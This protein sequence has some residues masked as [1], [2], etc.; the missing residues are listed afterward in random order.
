MRWVDGWGR[1]GRLGA[2]T[3]AGGP[4]GALL[5]TRSGERRRWEGRAWRWRVQDGRVEESHGERMPVGMMER[6]RAWGGRRKEA[7]GRRMQEPEGCKPRRR[8]RGERG[9]DEGRDRELGGKVRKRGRTGRVRRGILGR[10]AGR[11]GGG[12]WED[13]AG[14]SPACQRP[15]RR[16]THPRSGSRCSP[17]LRASRPGPH[18][19]GAGA[20]EHRAAPPPQP[21]CSAAAVSA[22]LR[23][24][25]LSIPPRGSLRRRRRR[26]RRLA[27]RPGLRPR[28]GGEG[29][30]R[31]WLRRCL[32]ALP[33]TPPLHS[34]PRSRGALAA[35]SSLALLQPRAGGLLRPVPAGLGAG[36]EAG[37]GVGGG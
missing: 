16:G 22:R 34:P 3:E 26:R 37:V 9:R 4:L 20:G 23:S 25:S 5:R 17:W 28:G 27:P 32:P 18:R 6:D 35:A 13:R 29:A 10:G 1:E 8:A 12:G 15:R 19:R 30:A 24:P 36:V 21:L 2:E 11:G 33:P 7:R 14:P 31:D